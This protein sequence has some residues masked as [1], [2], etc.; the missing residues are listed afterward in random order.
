MQKDLRLRGISNKHRMA[1][2]E[3]QFKHWQ[4]TDAGKKQGSRRKSTS[5]ITISREYGCAGFRIADQLAEALNEKP[6]ANIPPWTVYDR[7]L[8]DTVC[9]DYQFSRALVN[10]MDLQRDGDSATVVNSFPVVQTDQLVLV[11]DSGQI[12][13]VPVEDIRVIGRASRGVTVFNVSDDDRVVSVTRLRDE[14]DEGDED[15]DGEDENGEE[16]EGEVATDEI[17]SEGDAQP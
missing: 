14:D 9:Q 12:I 15:E 6:S 1:Q 13:R 16:I 7:M 5:F 11:A 2:V 8:V 4:A 10:S 3:E 17:A